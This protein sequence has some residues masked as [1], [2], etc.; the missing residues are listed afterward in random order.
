MNRLLHHLKVASASWVRVLMLIWRTNPWFVTLLLCC[1][2]LSGLAPAVQIQII[3]HIV[4]SASQAIIHRKA[5][6]FLQT[7]LLFGVLQGGLIILS[8]WIGGAQ[9]LLQTL[10]QL[11]L[12]NNL[13]VQIMLKALS[14]DIHYFEND[15]FYDKLQRANRE[16]MFRPYQIFTQMSSLGTQYVTLVSVIAVLFSL[17]WMIGVLMLLVP[18]PSVFSQIIYG[19]KGY[20]IERD[21]A[22]ERRRL[23]YIQLLVT[24]A[25]SIKELRLFRL[26][27]YFMQ[28][29]THFYNDFYKVDSSLAKRQLLA[30]IPFDLLTNLASVGTQIYVIIVTIIAGQIGI[31]ASYLQAII[32]VQRT[33]EGILQALSQLYQ[34]NLFVSNL[35][36]FL[37]VAPA[38]VRQGTRP[39]P[40]HIGAG[41]EFRNVS[42]HYP[43]TSQYV[44]RNMSLRLNSGECVALVGQNGAGKT[45]IVKL[46]TRLYEPTEGK[47]L[48][49]GHPLEEYNLDDLRKHMSVIFQD[50]V[51]Y[52]LPIRENVGFGYLEELDNDMRIRVATQQSNADQFIQQLPQRYD[53]M[54]G[55]MFEKGQQLSIGQWQKIALARAFMHNAPIVILDEPT[56]S[57][58]AETEAE[59]FGQLQQ[60][61]RGA[62]TLVIAHRFSTVRMADRILV[63]ER[64]QIIED[65]SHEA[66]MR[67]Q[68]TYARL[69]QLQAS[70]YVHH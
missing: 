2:V 43:G 9:Q 16:S 59:I 25:R 18:L 53:T 70:A 58:D 17:N 13:N 5:P 32:V 23:A 42:F 35:F 31:L 39:F 20:A 57:I 68:G 11:Q 4:Q 22:P 64:G 60:I 6:Q 63:L 15:T 46:L 24:D 62:T 21:R 56:A 50:F 41:I 3:G 19:Q 49:D 12:T 28:R 61:T 29:Y 67:L 7:A 27:R 30:L 66:L 10:L 8:S 45:T 37:D 69:F 44:I 38:N 26:G 47:I 52:E 36:E 1:M 33:M 65:G 51:Q 14:L 48:L 55:R 54:L 34:N 40:G